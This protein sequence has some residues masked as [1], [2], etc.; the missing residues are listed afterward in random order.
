[1]LYGAG[2]R[3]GETLSLTKADVNLQESVLLVRNTK[4]F[5]TRLVPIGPR[6]TSCLQ[7]YIERRRHLPCPSEQESAFLCTRPTSSRR[8]TNVLSATP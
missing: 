2:L 1:M 7:S 8:R 3:I 5:K 6:L 4:F